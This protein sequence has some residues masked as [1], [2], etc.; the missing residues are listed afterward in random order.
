MN[1]FYTDRCPR[2]SAINMVDKHAAGKMAL[3][4]AQLL[5]TAHRVLD[6]ELYIDKTKTGRKVKRW[7]LS[8]ER[9]QVLYS[10]THVNHP[11]A[12]WA[13]QSNNNYTWLYC[14]FIALLD[15]YTYRYDKIHKCSFL[16]ESLKN[17]PKN[18]PVGYLTLMPSAMAEEY[19]ISDDPLVNYRNYYRLGKARMHSWKRREIPE[20]INEN[21]LGEHIAG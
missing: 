3:E 19:I 6:G 17:L 4:A 16:I 13:R 20:W 21:L 5:S 12:I 1:I 14:H 18:I 9:D 7:R 11:S 15:E 8:D 10:A 2:Q